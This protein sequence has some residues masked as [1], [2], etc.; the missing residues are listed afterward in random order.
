MRTQVEKFSIEES[1]ELMSVAV[2]KI[3]VNLIDPDKIILFASE[4][5][6]VERTKK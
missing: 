5:V 1:V 2:S 6:E 4:V 3:L